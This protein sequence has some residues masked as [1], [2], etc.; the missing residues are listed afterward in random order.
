MA[1]PDLPSPPDPVIPGAVRAQLV[2]ASNSGIPRDAI[3]NTFHFHALPTLITDAMLTTLGDYIRDGYNNVLAPATNTV[4][5]YIGDGADRTSFKTLIHFYR[6]GDA[7]PRVPFDYAFTLGPNVGTDHGI[8]P[9][10]ALCV[11]YHDAVV[12]GSK[13][14]HGRTYIGPLH[15]NAI[16]A[17]APHVNPDGQFRVALVAFGTHLKNIAG[18]GLG[19]TI[20]FGI[21]SRKHANIT[22]VTG[23]FVDNEFDTQRRRGQ[24]ATIRS[25]F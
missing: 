22:S 18:A 16:A 4:A 1:D 2:I 19:F 7:H 12:S 10:V 5:S 8:P 3:V 20:N 24:R 14:R 23:G 21:L 25:T 13:L 17:A 15:S 6:L 11:S 9:E